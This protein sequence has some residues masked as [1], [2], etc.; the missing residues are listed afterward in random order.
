MTL[1]LENTSF[2]GFDFEKPLMD[3]EEQIQ[4]LEKTAQENQ[5]VGIGEEIQGLRTRLNELRAE[6]YGRLSPW[7][8]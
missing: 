6:I 1:T 2:K 4:A 7:Q 5:G 3:L 8:R